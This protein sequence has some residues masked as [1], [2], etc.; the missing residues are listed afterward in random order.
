MSAAEELQQL[1]NSSLLTENLHRKGVMWRFIPKRAPWYGGFWER[2]IGLTKTAL[3]KVLGRTF[4][5]LSS[6]QTLVVEVEAI[7]NDRPLTYVSPDERDP[8]PLTPAHMLY[9]RR[10]TSLPHPMVEDD[11]LDDPS[12]GTESDLKKRANTQALILKHFWK[13]WKLEYLTSQSSL[14]ELHKTTGNNIQ[15]VQIGDV[16]LVHDDTPRIRWDLA[17]IE[18]VIKGSDGLIRA[19]KI[20]TKGGRTNHLIA[21]LYPLEVRSTE[22]TDRL[23]S[24]PLTSN[25]MGDGDKE[26]QPESRPARRAALKA[27]QKFSEWAEV[28]RAPP[29]DV[30]D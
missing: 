4:A 16:V 7:L 18:D 15:K 11:E 6:L 29:E 8:E 24:T 23:N 26:G 28:L 14:R 13:R 5:T 19:A 3:K 1:F 22:F 10:I 12:Y 2:L 21:K 9:G 27:H 17:V 30:V 20:R 25:R